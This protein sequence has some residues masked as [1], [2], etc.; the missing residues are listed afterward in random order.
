MKRT[1]TIIIAAPH[2]DGLRTTAKMR[3]EYFRASMT[4]SGAQE[5]D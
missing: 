4:R 3:P 1:G 5:R 2:G